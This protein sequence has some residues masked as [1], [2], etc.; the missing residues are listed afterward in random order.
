MVEGS[1]AATETLQAH[2]KGARRRDLDLLR[3]LL[4]FG[5]VFFH[6]GR[7]FDTVDLPEGVKNL[8]PSIAATVFG[9]F[10]AL[11]GM[12][13][14]FAIAGF[15]TWHSLRK[16]T[17]RAFL[18]DRIQRLVVPFVFGVLALVPVQVYFHL[19]QAEPAAGMAYWQFLPKFFDVRL[20][21]DLVNAF[22]C[23][24]PE[25]GLFTTAHLWF[26]KDLFIFSVLL[27]PL[28]LYLQ[29]QRGG[30]ML[31]RLAD[32]LARPGMIWLLALPVAGFEALLVTATMGGSWNE[33]TYAVLLV[34][35]FLIAAEPRISQAT[36]RTWRSALAIA[37]VVEVIYIVGLY[38]LMEVYDVNPL[39]DYDAGS[40]LWRGVKSVGAFAWVV[41]IIGFGSRP[42]SKPIPEGAQKP[43]GS[44]GPVLQPSL[45][46]RII[47][48]GSEAFLA[49]YI[50]HQ[51]VIFTIGYYVVQW[52]MA[53]LL[54]FIAISFSS[55]AV[56]L[57]LYEVAVRRTK[58]T[59]WLFGMRV[60]MPTP[61]AGAPSR[62][63][64]GE[65]VV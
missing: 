20:C 5:L 1:L 18:V 58:V 17:G 6:T 52:E 56:T 45:G 64:A 51:T 53:A 63:G 35:G 4:V 15:A 57:L 43:S 62:K 14:M 21:P 55:L 47:A 30:I 31:G 2:S 37:L 34:I 23:P 60:S 54:K 32:F 8:P 9:G 33:Y 46:A 50:L 13:L 12:P 49:F 41:A 38:L 36:G 28:F 7:I 48:Y 11:W 65:G 26:L 59:R 44:S 22:I 3:V 25:T 29:G 24:D 40:L 42:R 10:F 39:H 61:A 27:L 19:K 16:R